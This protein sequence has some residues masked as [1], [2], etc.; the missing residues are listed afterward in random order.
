MIT[1]DQAVFPV[2]IV[3]ELYDHFIIFEGVA[4][5]ANE[6]VAVFRRPLQPYDP[7]Q[8]I[9]IFAGSWSPTPDSHEMGRPGNTGPTLGRYALTIQGM[10]RDM[11]E[12][13]GAAVHSVMAKMLRSMLY[14][15]PVLRLALHSLSAGLGDQTER[16]KK[17]DIRRQD[18]LGNQVQGEWLYLSQIELDVETETV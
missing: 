18:Y 15:D 14:S 4:V 1:A 2:N 5:P 8:A 6:R 10:V 13:R 12:E 11:D 3:N 9:G 17:W 7:T 16:L